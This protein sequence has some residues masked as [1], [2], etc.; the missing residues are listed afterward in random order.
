MK[1][2]HDKKLTSFL[3]HIEGTSIETIKNKK[4]PSDNTTGYRGVYFIRGKYLAKIVFQ[5]K[6]YY[7][8]SFKDIGDVQ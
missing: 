6:Q 7:L 2:E 4:V 3:N 1:R 8:G 5:R